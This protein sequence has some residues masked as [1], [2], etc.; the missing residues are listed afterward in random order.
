MHLLHFTASA[1]SNAQV[2]ALETVF[3]STGG[4]R[5]NFVTMNGFI[6]EYHR[7]FGVTNL[8]GAPWDFRLDSAGNYA[9][10]PCAARSTGKNFAGI[11]CQCRVVSGMNTCSIT[12]VVV[13]DANL[14]GQI[15]DVIVAL[16]GLALTV[17][18]LCT[19]SLSGIIPAA[20][21][22]FT[23]LTVLDFQDCQ[24]SGSIPFSIGELTRLEKLYLARN[25]LT[26]TIPRSMGNLTELESLDLTSNLLEG[27]IPQEFSVLTKVSNIFLNDNKLK[28]S[29][30]DVG[31]L[32]DLV[33]LDLS[34]NALTGSLPASITNLHKLT[35]LF[36][37]RNQLESDADNN[38][39]KF[40]DPGVHSKLTLLDMSYNRFSGFIDPAAFLLPKLE[41]LLLA[42][43]CFGG[44][45]PTNICTPTN[46]ITLDLSNLGSAKSCRRY[47]WADSPF[48]NVFNAFVPAYRLEG[49]FPSCL[50]E[51]PLLETLHASG[52]RLPGAVPPRVS[53][54][55]KAI[56]MSRNKLHGHISVAL[57]T[58][59]NLVQLDLHRN[60]IHGNLDSFK[61]ADENFYT[62]KGFSLYLQG[63]FLSG[64][65]PK[66]LHNIDS[67]NILNGNVFGCSLDRSELPINNP[68]KSGYQCGSSEMNN[69]MYAFI[70]ISLTAM[71]LLAFIR[72]SA[73]MQRCFG[74]FKLWL[75]IAAGREAV[76]K[77]F[78]T[79]HMMRLSWHL[80]VQRWF[81]LMIGAAIVIV[82]ICYFALSGYH[83]QLVDNSYAWVSTA[84]Y[85]T[86]DKSLFF[87][88]TLGILF[89]C[90]VWILIYL[91]ER[92]APVKKQLVDD[93]DTYKEAA[94][95]EKMRITFFTMLR[96]LIILLFVWGVILGITV[97]YVKIQVGGDTSRT[98]QGI[99]KFSFGLFKLVWS[100]LCTPWFFETRWLHFGVDV[101][102]HD[103]MIRSIFGTRVKL[104]FMINT[105][106][107][108]I[109]IISAVCV[110]ELCFKG[111][112]VQSSDVQSYS[113]EQGCKT[114]ASVDGISSSFCTEFAIFENQTEIELPFSYGYSCSDS[115][116]R[117]FIPLYMQ[118][119][120]LLIAKSVAAFTFLAWDTFESD[121]PARAKEGY[122]Y[123][124]MHMIRKCMPIEYL[125]YDNTRR[126]MMYK[127]GS[128][129]VTMTRNWMTK[130]FGI[131]MANVLV[132][133]SFGFAAPPLAIMMIISFC[134]DSYVMQLIMGRF[135]DA[136][137]SVVLE[138][139][140]LTEAIDA[141]YK[142]QLH[143]ISLWK[144]ERMKEEIK[145]M[146]EPWGA[147]AAL[148]EANHVCRHTP[149]SALSLGR[150]LFILLPSFL[151][152]LLLIDIE[153]NQNFGSLLWG[154]ALAMFI[155]GYVLI[156]LTFV[157]KRYG[158]CLTN[159][160][161]NFV[162]DA[163]EKMSN[164]G[165]RT[166]V[167]LEE[168]AG[169]EMVTFPSSKKDSEVGGS[170]ATVLNPISNREDAA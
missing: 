28:G 130:D 94:L 72:Q 57:A 34:R 169:R 10:D 47:I 41:T 165:S 78:D 8:T 3:N 170:V 75:R 55:L 124:L 83:D 27:S 144:R 139:N 85:L 69:M 121:Q 145:D 93:D 166:K 153:N 151:I 12:E 33:T 109:P 116:M 89:V 15:S 16:K 129:F 29:I 99:F 142:P 100:F 147:V 45:L 11:G 87:V 4:P 18:D 118:M 84:A 161:F 97:S 80:Q 13:H 154:A 74:K 120:I 115:I 14:V 92:V 131:H 24:V 156:L 51:L 167:E 91:D 101:K 148:R 52:N 56:T 128:A 140:R 7:S 158:L 19:N 64:E 132:L 60:H 113:L 82:N 62:K 146:F 95:S 127:E 1:T 17:L 107:I 38:A 162:H 155:T 90:Y 44:T 9:L 110:D 119:A 22:E 49:I 168:A 104:A 54:T 96:L 79:T 135:L 70:A 53:S 106:N 39:F 159:K 66:A 68:N 59:P 32:V 150:F 98:I 37:S 149:I 58:S 123:K 152:A 77:V 67:I 23:K 2:A 125:T 163:L 157:Y 65:I 137:V 86:G 71:T 122:M 73:G 164:E 141:P 5:W 20:I 6:E 46:L 114:Y 63:N 117:V 103:N 50:F 160:N 88:L 30:P 36:V 138:H 35:H 81:T 40:L 25:R 31:N 102:H 21:G 43:N 61:T 136:E 133:L 105:V 111:A 134:M 126:K 26:G 48:K 42:S 108:F 143:F 112:F 76:A